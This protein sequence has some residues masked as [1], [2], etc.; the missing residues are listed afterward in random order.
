VAGSKGRK[1]EEWLKADC[2][3]LQETNQ[4]GNDSKNK[5]PS[6]S[7]F[8]WRIVLRLLILSTHGSAWFSDLMG[9][10]KRKKQKVPILSSVWT[11]ATY[12]YGTNT[13][14]GMNKRTLS[15]R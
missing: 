5:S 8:G 15:A 14:H 2:V 3:F 7:H 4:E 13:P 12:F 10:R 9:Q 11:G 1:R 6:V